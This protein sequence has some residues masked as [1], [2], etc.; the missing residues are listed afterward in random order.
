MT[1]RRF[2]LL[3]NETD[4]RVK[5]QE[6]IGFGGKT[7]KLSRVTRGLTHVPVLDE[8]FTSVLFTVLAKPK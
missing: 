1:I 8:F 7:F 4:F 6:K 2:N 3:L 5:H